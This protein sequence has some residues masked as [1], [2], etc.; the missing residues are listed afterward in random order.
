MACRSATMGKRMSAI[1]LVAQWHT[2]ALRLS[3]RG[4]RGSPLTC[5]WCWWGNQWRGA[6]KCWCYIASGWFDPRDICKGS[7]HANWM[8]TCRTFPNSLLEY[9]LQFCVWN[10]NVGDIY[11]PAPL[12]RHAKSAPRPCNSQRQAP[13]FSCRYPQAVCWPGRVLLGRRGCRQVGTLHQI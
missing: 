9:L 8:K 7:N 6:C 5:K 10:Y 2:W 3:P 12:F 4:T 11:I 1:W 13:G